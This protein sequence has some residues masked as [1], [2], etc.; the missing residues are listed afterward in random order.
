H[1]ESFGLDRLYEICKDARTICDDLQISR[2][3]ARPFVGTSPT[4]FKR[5]HHR[6][7]FSQLPP[8]TTM[9]EHVLDA[10]LPTVGIGK[11]WNIF[12]GRGIQHSLETE[13]NTDGLRVLL[14]A[15]DTY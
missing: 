2:V 3:I 4:D 15:I 14:P 9:M 13:D 7:D 1:E 10:G 6:K 11:I 8:R 12:A 5:T